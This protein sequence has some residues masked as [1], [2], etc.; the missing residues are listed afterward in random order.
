MATEHKVKQG[1]CI[2]SIAGK[3]GCFP[4]TIWDDPLN[5]ELK[6]KRKESNVLYAGDI[7]IIPEKDPKQESCENEHRH[8]FKRQHT[9]TLLRVI[10]HDEGDQLLSN[11]RYMLTIA[12]QESEGTILTQRLKTISFLRS[13]RARPKD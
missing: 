13:F 11:R 9:Q 3:Y 1:E 7:L 5:V 8:K 4:E 10:L 2:S 6:E 12:G